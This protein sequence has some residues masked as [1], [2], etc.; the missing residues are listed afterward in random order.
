MGVPFSEELLSAYFTGIERSIS[1]AKRNKRNKVKVLS[2]WG[3]TIQ[4]VMFEGDYVI[5][6]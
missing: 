6:L 5:R 2:R 1:R 4:G 3:I